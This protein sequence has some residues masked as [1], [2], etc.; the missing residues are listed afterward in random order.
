MPAKHRLHDYVCFNRKN[1]R[2]VKDESLESLL[3]VEALKE[4]EGKAQ[5]ERNVRKSI[6]HFLERQAL[7]KQL[8]DFDLDVDDFH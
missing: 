6:E 4:P 5:G 7:R 2:L 1:E 3:D 8:V